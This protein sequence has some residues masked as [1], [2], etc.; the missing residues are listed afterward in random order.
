VE[1]SREILLDVWREVC[2]HIEISESSAAIAQI[3]ARRIPVDRVVVRR[4][5]T[6]RSCV[7]TVA[8]SADKRLLPAA[9]LRTECSAEQ[10]HGLLAWCRKGNVVARQSCP[11]TMELLSTVIAHGIEGNILAGPLA[12]NGDVL[13]IVVLVAEPPVEFEPSHTVLMNALLEPF[14]VALEND[15]RLRQIAALRAAAEADKQLLLTRLGRKDLDDVIIG[16]K[17]GLRTVMERVE[18]VARSDVPVLIFGET[19]TGKELIAR[20]IHRRSARYAGPVIRVNCGAFPSE[21][22]DSH[23]FGHER[24]AFTGAI[25]TRQGWFERADAGTLFLDEIGEL[26]PAAQIRL[27]RVLQDGWMERVGGNRPIHVDVRV[28]AATHGDLGAMVAEGTFRED[29]WYRLAVFPIFLPPLRERL[30]D[31]PLLARHFARKAA[32]R[33]GLPALTPSD[34]DMELLSAYRWPGNVRE[35]GSVMDRAAL[36]GNG[37]RLEVEKS[38]GAM[39]SGVTPSPDPAVDVGTQ[40]GTMQSVPSLD[41]VMRRHIETTLVQTKGRIEGPHGA[42]GLLKINPHTLRGRMR[43]LGIDWARFREHG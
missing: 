14:T 40:N 38:L 16:D 41:E 12:K 37:N 7:E 33:F 30:E 27:L 19:G 26:P 11:E 2:R 3:L 10:L 42:A 34:H 25:D 31:I 1:V 15:G 22:I 17:S 6:S 9:E 29:L 32:A 28:V 4:I 24:G 23:L 13:G 39:V 18:I 21:L 8:V 20:E 43:R 35:L 36:I 5:D